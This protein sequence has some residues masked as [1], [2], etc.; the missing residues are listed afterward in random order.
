MNESFSYE[1]FC[2]GS[3]YKRF[4]EKRLIAKLMGYEVQ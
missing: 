3:N 4:D 1:Q 2:C